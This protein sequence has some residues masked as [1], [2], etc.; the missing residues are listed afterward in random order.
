MKQIGFLLAIILEIIILSTSCS[1]SK[2]NIINSNEVQKNTLLNILHNYPKF[3]D[4]IMSKKDELNVQIIYSQIDRKKN[5]KA[6]FTDHYFNYNPGKYFYPASTVKLP[7]AILA[8][9]KLNKLKIPGLDKNTT[10]ITEADYSGQTP[11]YN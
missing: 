11:V 9:Q 1:P 5:G 3:F 2:I 10:M 7:V 8:L 6:K 4:S